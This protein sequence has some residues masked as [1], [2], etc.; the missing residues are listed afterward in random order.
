MLFRSALKAFNDAG[1]SVK[2]AEIYAEAQTRVSENVARGLQNNTKMFI[3]VGSNGLGDT[4]T[5][6]IPSI[7]AMKESGLSLKDILGTSETENGPKKAKKN[8]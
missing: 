4:L 1:I 6:L 3:P 2:I 7:A 5:S 8:A